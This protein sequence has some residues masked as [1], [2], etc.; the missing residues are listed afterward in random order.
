MIVFNTWNAMIGCGT[1]TI[2]WAFQQSG[3][4]LGVV[5]TAVACIFAFVTNY[6]LLRVAGKDTNFSDTMHRYFPS[7][8]WAVSMGCFIVNFY[9]GIILF[10][11]VLSQSL[12]P[13]ILFAMGSEAPIETKTDWSQFSLSYSCL[14][15]L[16]IVLIMTAPR[17]TAYV[18]KINAFGVV[19]VMIFLLFIMYNGFKSMTST[20]YVYSEFDYNTAV[21]NPDQAYTAW[22]PLSGSQFTPLMGIL[23]GGF[24]FHNMSLSLASN[25]KYPEHNT[26]NIFIGFLLVFLT[27]SIIGITGVYGFTGS[28][29]ASFNPSVNLIKENCL[30]MMASDDKLATFIRACILCQ[31]LTVNTLLFGLL[32][33]QII[34]FYNGVTKGIESVT[35][36]QDEIRLSRCKNFMLSFTMTLPP[37]ALAIWYPYVGKLGALIAAFS[38]MF[39]I[40]ILPLATFTKAVKL[41]QDKQKSEDCSEMELLLNSEQK[42]FNI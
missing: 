31:L 26:R 29:F 25:A 8:G 41:Q 13:I 5:L 38:T 2:P 37:L 33:S 9:V 12:Y 32:R 1:V 10:F 30:N 4:M 27:Y 39:V 35:Q 3:I 11:Q 21:A 17:D 34:L 15:L 22:I 19:F 7:C 14:I 23:G 42:A 6:L 40:Y 16:V 18:Q 20:N 24:Y 28:A 36:G